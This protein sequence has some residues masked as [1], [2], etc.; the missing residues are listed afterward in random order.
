[1]QS[2]V[3]GDSYWFVAVV[4]HGMPSL[5]S[6]RSRIDFFNSYRLTHAKGP[7]LLMVCSVTHFCNPASRFSFSSTAFS[8]P[9][10]SAS[11]S[12]VIRRGQDVTRGN[13]VEDQCQPYDVLHTRHSLYC[14]RLGVRAL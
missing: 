6:A 5:V 2:A 3:G 12:V 13:V 7:T 14:E 4:A 1:M 10:F 8:V 11:L 9:A